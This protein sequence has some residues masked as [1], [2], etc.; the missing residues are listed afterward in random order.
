MFTST[1]SS[2]WVFLRGRKYPQG[3]QNDVKFR[4]HIA[5]FL[6][7]STY[8]TLNYVFI[9]AMSICFFG[10]QFGI[11]KQT[12]FEIDENKHGNPI[13]NFNGLNNNNKNFPDREK[14]IYT[15]VVSKMTTFFYMN[16]L[17][18]HYLHVKY[19]KNK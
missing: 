6:F 12:K 4:K 18:R 1:K 3:T 11:R 13:R 16:G 5:F 8:S 2:Y 17:L 15:A 14:R 7:F 9:F 19:V 10:M